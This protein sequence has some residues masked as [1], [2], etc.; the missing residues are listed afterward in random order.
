MSLGT[1]NSILVRIEILKFRKEE[2]LTKLFDS[3]W[4]FTT[5]QAPTK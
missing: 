4:P 5:K 3:I 2:I 1:Q